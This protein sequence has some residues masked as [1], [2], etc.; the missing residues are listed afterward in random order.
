MPV[1]LVCHQLPGAC[2]LLHSSCWKYF[3]FHFYCCCHLKVVQISNLQKRSR[4]NLECKKKNTCTMI[5]VDYNPGYRITNGTAFHLTVLLK[6]I[7][8]NR[9]YPFKMISILD[10]TVVTNSDHYLTDIWSLQSPVS[11]YH[12]NKRLMKDHF[13]DVR[14]QLNKCETDVGR[15]LTK[16]W[17]Q[18]YKTSSLLNNNL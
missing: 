3:L 17:K 2:C 10:V 11:N 1:H 5:T 15:K 16:S 7:V 8:Q 9:R 14:F 18:H 6:Y 4:Y 13:P 12:L